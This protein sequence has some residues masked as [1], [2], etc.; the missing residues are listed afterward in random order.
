M[1]EPQ[2]KCI[3]EGSQFSLKRTSNHQK[4]LAISTGDSDREEA[5]PNLHIPMYIDTLAEPLSGKW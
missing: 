5:H 4:S 1:I 3:I 2:Y